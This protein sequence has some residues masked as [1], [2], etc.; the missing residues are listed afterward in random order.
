MPSSKILTSWWLHPFEK[1]LVK[2]CQSQIGSS[3]QEG[4]KKNATTT[5]LVVLDPRN[6]YTIT[7]NLLHWS[8]GWGAGP[9]NSLRFEDAE[10]A[11]EWP[12]SQG[13]NLK[14][15]GNHLS[16]K[17]S[18]SL[19]TPDFTWWFHHPKFEIR[20]ST[21]ENPMASFVD[22]FSGCR[23]WLFF[24]WPL[25]YTNQWW[26]GAILVMIQKSG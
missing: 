13:M 12:L 18:R 10:D 23:N 26:R 14:R 3:P 5:S 15:F 16:F 11:I 22:V 2:V 6:S 19:Q 24:G 4:V 7:P 21:S 17:L 20:H 25:K 9:S 8:V 1:R